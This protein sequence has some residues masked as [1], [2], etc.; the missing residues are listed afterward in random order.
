VTKERT[1]GLVLYSLAAVLLA[2]GT[3]WWLASAPDEV[4]PASQ[5]QKWRQTAEELLPD[6]SDQ[7][8]ADTL[9]LESGVEQQVST[10]VAAGAYSISVVCVGGPGSTARVALESS[11]LGTVGDSGLGLSCEQ[12]RSPESFTVQLDDGFRM[13][14][15][16]GEDSGVVFRYVLRRV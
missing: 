2:G 5:E 9:T 11:G 14:V 4:R 16:V 13:T 15:T 8:D 6:V 7:E 10:S 12:E 3:A 1:R